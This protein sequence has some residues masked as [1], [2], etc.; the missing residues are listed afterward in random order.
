LRK[1]LLNRLNNNILIISFIY[2]FC[3]TLILAE[4]TKSIQE[5][6]N[7]KVI[8]ENFISFYNNQRLIFF[9]KLKEN[10]SFSFQF[11][12]SAKIQKVIIDNVHRI[13]SISKYKRSNQLKTILFFD[14]ITIQNIFLSLQ[15]RILPTNTIQCNENLKMSYQEKLLG[16][17]FDSKYYNYTFNRS[18]SILLGFGIGKK[19]DTV[20]DFYFSY[21]FSGRYFFNPNTSS[22]SFPSYFNY[23]LNNPTNLVS[24][25][26]TTRS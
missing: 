13:L 6:F 23:Y 20:N 19:K 5:D 26:L 15:I 22:H 18:S 14:L 17:S 1:N 2:L 10:L 16:I 21:E 11:F 3:N 25:Y 8:R 12:F 9:Y 7:E 4:E 24:A